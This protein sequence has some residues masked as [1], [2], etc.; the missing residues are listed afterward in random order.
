MKGHLFSLFCVPA[1][2]LHHDVNKF[3]TETSPKK[4]NAHCYDWLIEGYTMCQESCMQSVSIMADDSLVLPADFLLA[5][6]QQKD[7]AVG[8]PWDN[9]DDFLK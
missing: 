9:Q 7:I 3:S 6:V 5:S 1:E 4:R 2:S 8:N